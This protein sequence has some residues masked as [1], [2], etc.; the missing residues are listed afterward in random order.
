MLCCSQ[1]KIMSELRI[2]NISAPKEIKSALEHM[3]GDIEVNHETRKGGNGH[4][5][6]GKNRILNIDVAIKFYYWGGDSKYHAEPKTL[7]R[8]NSSNVLKVLDAGKI[9]KEWAYFITPFYSNGDLD[10]MLART[11]FGNIAAIDTTCQLLDGITH[12]H[13]NRLLHRDLKPANIYL[14]ENGQAVIGDFGSIKKLPEG[15]NSI[16]ASGHS[17]LYRPPESVKTNEYGFLGDIYQCG[18]VLY[19]LL[20]GYLPYSE[21]AWLSKKECKL[22][23]SF[24]DCMKKTIY[25]DECLKGRICRGKI[26]D[27]STLPDWVPNKLKTVI[28]KAANVNLQKRFQ[29]ASAFRVCL[30]NMRGS[31]PNWSLVNGAIYFSGTTEYRISGQEKSLVIQKRRQGGRW[32]RDNSFQVDSIRNAI[33]A[34]N[35]RVN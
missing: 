31:V 23:D 10:D 17:I 27:I 5:F 20:G 11:Q 6:F 8:L 24:C 16:P 26:I 18:I 25:A 2:N 3:A 19:Q 13:K 1:V 21:V 7:A 30:N 15:S 4:T 14:G 9:S 29:S 32:R 34:I 22:Y 33:H 35:E 28:R 12:L